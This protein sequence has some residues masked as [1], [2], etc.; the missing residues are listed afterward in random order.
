VNVLL[1]GGHLPGHD[2]LDLLLADGEA[3]RF[4]TPR[5]SVPGSHGT[6]CTLSAAITAQLA[7][8]LPLPAAV[9][10]AKDYL[11]RALRD[12]YQFH[13]PSAESVHALNQGTVPWSDAD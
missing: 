9:A 2:C 3:H 13:H 5:L 12:S 1:K 4:T 7:H 10:A 11:T 6:G 8:G